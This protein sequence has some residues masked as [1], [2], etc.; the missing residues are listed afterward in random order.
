MNRTE[1]KKTTARIMLKSGKFYDMSL[2]NANW[3]IVQHN[4]QDFVCHLVGDIMYFYIR[5]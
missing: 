4:V 5:G 1:R 2:Y 3:W